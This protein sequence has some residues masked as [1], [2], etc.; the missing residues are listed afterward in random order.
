MDEKWLE[1]FHE[2]YHLAGCCCQYSFILRGE[3]V[4]AVGYFVLH[5]RALRV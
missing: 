5:S 2:L 4:Q 3:S 1:G